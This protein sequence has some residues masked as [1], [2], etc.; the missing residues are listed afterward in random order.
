MTQ[1]VN[2]VGGVPRTQ[3]A[4]NCR[5]SKLGGV[6][7]Q[8]V[9][10]ILRYAPNDDFEVNIIGDYT[11][12]ERTIP[13][14]VLIH[15]LAV[16]NPNTNAAPGMP[17]DDRFIC[18]RYCSFITTGQPAGVFTGVAVPPGG[19][20]LL[21]TSGSDR[22]RYN[23]WGVSGQVRWN[24]SDMFS[25]DSITGYQA[26]NTSFDADDDLSPANLGFG[27]NHLTHW[28]LSQ[29]LRL[30]GKLGDTIN[31][32]LGGYYFKQST[33][34]NSY[35][36]LRYVAV[37]GLGPLY[38]LQ[39]V[40]PDVIKADSKAVFMHA[41]WEI[42]SGLT[43]G[44]GLRYTDE[45]KTY[46]YYRLNPDGTINAYLDPIGAV[47]GAGYLGPDTADANNNGDTTETVQA[48]TGARATYKGN[49]WDYRVSLNYRFS[50][51]LL[52]Y[53]N[54]S[55]GFKGGGTNPRP[56]N[57]AQVQSFGPESL[58]AYEIGFKS[59]LFDRRM[60][61]NVTAFYNRYKDIQ[62]PLLSCPQYGGP[63]PCALPANAGNGH[64]KG[65][66]AELFLRPIEGLQIDASAS[67]LDFKYTSINPLAGG[68]TNLAGAQ[69][70]DP[71]A[72]SPKWKW[73]IGAQYRF[74]L[75][76]D[77]G[78][79]TPRIDASYESKVYSGPLV[80]GTT[81]TLTFLP[82][83]TIANARL[84]WRNPGDDL[85][86]SL[87]VTNLF[88][89]YYFLTNFDLRGV[90]EGFDK[91]QPARPREWAFSIKKKF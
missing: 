45:K 42:L 48:L 61:L 55:T 90:G 75:G 40:Q 51:E 15:T 88:N 44:G 21:A 24:L 14:E 73:S 64:H 87:E 47:Y 63:G 83:Y 9:R 4:G 76:D 43:L 62:I 25:I 2:P 91:A 72:G 36:D 69:L 53:A 23:G 6:G 34:Y 37:P 86:A 57:A 46:D 79:L 16:D 30:N 71:V 19:Q 52:V 80:I 3:P 65:V 56:F 66:E 33:T 70:S 1:P 58:T 49:R 89:K 5:I 35:Q 10:G 85:E 12:D 60:R 74:E 11:H 26:F 41:D 18:G 59:D 54:I 31:F 7:Y 38:P 17:Y 84:T 82:A 13:G 39:F 68:P 29:E 27:Q 81:R 8:A 22:S 78:S 20:P 67:Y 50:P 32:T 77:I 28:N